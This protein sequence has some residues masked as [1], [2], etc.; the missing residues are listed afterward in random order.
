[1]GD[2][3]KQVKVDNW[4]IYFLQRLKHFFN[5][6]DYCDLTLQFQDNAQL[7]V[8]RLV[9]SAC[10]EYF[11]VLERTCEMYEDCLVMPEDLQA[12]IVVPIV[13]FMYT[14]QLEFKMDLL[15]RLHQCSE[16]M[17]MPVLTKLLDSH[18]PKAKAVQTYAST[19]IAKKPVKHVEGVKQ[20][21]KIIS[22][23]QVETTTPVTYKRSHNNAFAENTT[24]YRD[25]KIYL[26]MNKTSPVN[27][28]SR[29]YRDPS[30]IP[31]D[32]RYSKKVVS[33]DPR[34][35]RYEIPEE[36]DTDN[37]FENSFCNIS[38]T[39]QPLMVHPE[40]RKQ[41]GK[42][43]KPGE[44]STSKKYGGSTVNI[45]Q[46][47]KPIK[48]QEDSIFEDTIIDD[49]DI[50]TEEYASKPGPSRDSSQLFD[51]IL[52]KNQ[53][54]K[55][56][57][58]T[59]NS[60]SPANLDHA[61][62]ISE[63]LKKYPHLVKSNK[64]IKLKI[65]NTS[66]KT[67][68]KQKQSPA[69]PVTK[70][71]KVE[72]DVD[73]TY[74]TDV[75]DSMQ[76][77]KLIALGAENIDGPWIC[78]I[79]GTPGKA[80]N[81][82]S[83][84]KFRR[85]LVDI[86]NEKPVLNICEYCG[87]KSI[88]RN[89]L[90]HHLYTKHGVA[91]PP[92][93]RFPKCNHC[94]YIAL[95]EGLLVK[96]KLSH[97]DVK[98]FR[99][100]V[101]PAAFH[102]SNLLLAHIRQ[103]G[104]KYSA[105]RKSNLQ[106]IYC[107]KNFLREINLC[108][109]LK[110][111]HKNEAIQDGILDDS[112]D[113]QEEKKA[114]VKSEPIINEYQEVGIQYQIQQRPDGNISIVT[115]TT[116]EQAP[117]QDARQTILN[118]G[119]SGQALTH[120]NKIP[121]RTQAAQNEFIQDVNLTTDNDTHEEIV[122]IDNTEY[123]MRDN[124]LIP[125]RSKEVTQEYILSDHGLESVTPTTSIEYTNQ[126]SIQH[127][128]ILLKNPN[129]MTE[130][131]PIY[132]SNEEE[133]KAIMASNQPIIF[134]SSDSN[135][136]LTVLT[137]PHTSTLETATIDLDS[138]Q[139]NDMM[140]LP[141]NYPLNVSEAVPA[142]N[143]NIVVVYSHQV[144]GDN[145]QFQ[146]LTTQ[147]LGAQFVQS[148]AII[149]Q[150]FETITTTAPIMNT[151]ALEKQVQEVWQSDLHQI[152]NTDQIE[153]TPVTVH[154]VSEEPNKQMQ[155]TNIVESNNNI[156]ELPQVEL[157]SISKETD[158]NMDITPSEN[159]EDMITE[160]VLTSNL[161]ENI[162][163]V[164]DD[165]LQNTAT[166][167]ISNEE[168]SEQEIQQSIESSNEPNV[169]TADNLIMPEDVNLKNTTVEDTELIE[170]QTYTQPD[171]IESQKY[172]Q[173]ESNG[174]P[175]Y[176]NMD[177]SEHHE[178]E[179]VINDIQTVEGDSI[180]EGHEQLATVSEVCEVANNTEQMVEIGTEKTQ[181]INTEWTETNEPQLQEPQE[182]QNAPEIIFQNHSGTQAT[183]EQGETCELEESI[184]NIQQEVNKQM[185]I[186]HTEQEIS[187]EVT[188]ENDITDEGD[189]ANTSQDEADYVQE[190]VA[191]VPVDPVVVQE[192]ISSLLNDWDDNDSQEG[193]ETTN[194]NPP[195]VPQE[196]IANEALEITEVES[197]EKQDKIKSLVSDWDEDEEE[198]KE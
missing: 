102:S 93:Y 60:K 16:I 27:N 35:T 73:F 175:V 3:V 92:Q 179:E 146:L 122:M 86:H 169:N 33:G 50:Y 2:D 110:T 158:N 78:L 84:Y 83:Y 9:L 152:V 186:A 134:D 4:G 167:E 52:E 30:P 59:K 36:L 184:E 87:Q 54:S 100:N 160:E 139:A 113:E 196:N 98:K 123:I 108:T 40:T 132:V 155:V 117:R 21:I 144:G 170:S 104:H 191:P 161:D 109:H 56:T 23:T 96:H 82:T 131:I 29:A 143:S 105:E 101:C 1:M 180:Q 127:A 38:Y 68:K 119:L 141:D 198:S 11:E 103:T 128:N 174:E 116:P 13:N 171:H 62:I 153:I 15:E 111:H 5:R 120:K 32:Q 112:E 6:T 130:S 154:G 22:S 58:E 80:M 147:G 81:F 138:T 10:T 89:F 61:K 151:Q 121:K 181:T 126:E 41:Y 63:V 157:P 140:I 166:M 53:E 148:S 197:P 20:M 189:D 85:H 88:K 28:G 69:L 90:L 25:K 163:V 43:P 172:P 51:Q 34:P 192:K 75:L 45:L 190:T 49:P 135:K 168:P 125:R 48:Q 177:V 162:E 42:R 64:N 70:Q 14:G 12:D 115:K 91:P 24:V 133:Y 118:S 156:S 31:L 37:I 137:A 187:E 97:A 159:Q 142:E 65:L 67:I 95:S 114:V 185:A 71:I 44:A 74:E 188:T 150:N 8:H 18:R 76:A 79:C 182:N 57:I 17:N 66:S 55:L 194:D 39:T 106:C 19:S 149:T 124:Q 77:A 183:N 94:S 107:L 145:K 72:K 176:E 26:P 178:T 173:I 195:I 46:C 47:K 7:K 164:C 129:N 165:N 193:N 136:T 99:C